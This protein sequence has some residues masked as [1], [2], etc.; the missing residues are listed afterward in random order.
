M[1]AIAFDLL[2]IGIYFAIIVAI[3]V[4]FSTRNRDVSE[5]AL[6]G[7]SIPWWAVLA[8]RKRVRVLPG[9]YLAREVDGVTPGADRLRVAMVAPEDEMRDGL[10]RLRS[11]LYGE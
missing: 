3:G 2:V 11:C 4:H 8:S 10:T 9:A 6:G 1:S 5:F 7:R